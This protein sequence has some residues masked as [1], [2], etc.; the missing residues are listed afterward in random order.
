MQLIKK[1]KKNEALK[2]KKI[3]SILLLKV[4]KSTEDSWDLG[5]M[6][7]IKLL[8]FGLQERPIFAHCVTLCNIQL[9]AHPHH[10]H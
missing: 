4:R 6:S 8:S 2:K 7:S 9:P 3:Y 10:A 1:L 5:V